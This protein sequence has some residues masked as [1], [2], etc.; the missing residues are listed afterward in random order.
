MSIRVQ[1]LHDVEENTAEE[2]DWQTGCGRAVGLRL[3][4]C[5]TTCRLN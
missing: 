2:A 5:A 3:D 4:R 1:K